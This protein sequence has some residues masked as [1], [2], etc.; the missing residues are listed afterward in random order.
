[1]EMNEKRSIKTTHVLFQ[2]PVIT[3]SNLLCIIRLFILPVVIYYLMQHENLRALLFIGIGVITD[4]LDGFIARSFNKVSEFGKFL[5]PLVDKITVIT[6]LGFI[7]YRNFHDYASY[8]LIL[9]F[10]TS[11][12][13]F[14]G[15]CYIIAFP[16]IVRKNGE[17]PSSNLP[18][19]ITA[20]ISV[21]AVVLYVLE[22]NPW[23]DVMMIIT[24][25]MSITAG[26]IYFLRDFH[27]AN[28][29][30]KISWANRITLLRIVLSPLFLLIFFYDGDYVYD[31][32]LLVFKI[33]ALLLVIALVVSDRVDGVLARSRNEISDFGKLLDPFADKISFITIFLCFMATGWASVWMVA[34]I[35][36]REAMVSFLRTLAATERIVLAAQPS[37]KI[38]TAL[39]STV[40]ITL[41]S[42]SFLRDL[43]DAT[44]LS[45]AAGTFFDIWDFTWNWLPYTLMII[46]TL[47][48]AS[49]GLD[50]LWRNRKVI[51]AALQNK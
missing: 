37:G 2:K 45:V 38:K 28:K 29:T 47:A 48:T 41:L 13:F 49:S 43:A 46:V 39:Q 35:Y 33:M 17:V 26:V 15:I 23:S 12:L 19:K 30:I 3:V 14:I 11:F 44:G 1:M 50:Y 22:L 18:G 24:I 42:L 34:I 8:P 27:R 36:Y 5:D 4:M 10:G 51:K 20:L 6:V 31:N 16:L 7:A 9:L 40:A 25:G 32:N 21:V